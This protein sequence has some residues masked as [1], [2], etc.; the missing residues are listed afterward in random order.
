MMILMVV[1]LGGAFCGIKG[2]TKGFLR[3]KS[4]LWTEKC[5]KGFDSGLN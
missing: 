4:R 1:E 3:C 2:V 5:L